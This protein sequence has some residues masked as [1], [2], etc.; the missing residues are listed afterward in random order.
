MWRWTSNWRA[1]PLRLLAS[2][3]FRR[4]SIWKRRWIWASFSLRTSRSSVS[5]DSATSG[6]LYMAKR[7]SQAARFKEKNRQTCIVILSIWYQVQRPAEGKIVVRFR[8]HDLALLPDRLPLPTKRREALD[9]GPV[10]DKH[11]GVG[12]GLGNCPYDD[13]KSLAVRFRID[14]REVSIGDGSSRNR[15]DSGPCAPFPDERPRRVL[16]RGVLQFGRLPVE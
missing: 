10:F 3:V 1:A 7:A 8:N 11:R 15:V 14:Q 13:L 9:C 12:A 16:F 4:R 6:R 2:P 5:A